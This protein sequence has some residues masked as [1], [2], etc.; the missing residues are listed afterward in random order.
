MAAAT[1]QIL[2]A[3]G[4]VAGLCYGVG[5]IALLWVVRRTIFRERR[6]ARQPKP[7]EQRRHAARARASIE[8]IEGR[9]RWARYQRA[10]K[11][12]R[13]EQPTAA[14]QARLSELSSGRPARRAG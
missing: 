11:F 13:G 6:R 2:S 14:Q 10:V 9:H 1:E 4:L 8:D 7:D 3:T 12:R 5:I